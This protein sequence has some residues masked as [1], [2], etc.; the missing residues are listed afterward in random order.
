VAAELGAGEAV[1]H[2]T[3]QAVEAIAHIG[4]PGGDEGAR[5]WTQAEH[6]LVLLQHGEPLRNGFAGAAPG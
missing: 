1:S 5:G 2:K 4:G 6:R 3:V